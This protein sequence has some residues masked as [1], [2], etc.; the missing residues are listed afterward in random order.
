MGFKKLEI[1]DL[2]G[3]P[4]LLN[5]QEK[6]IANYS[7]TLIQNATGYEADIT[8]LSMI[9]KQVIEQ[10]F[11]KVAPADYMPVKVGEGAWARN[12]VTFRSFVLG[13]DFSTGII[14][15]GS[16]N[17][18]QASADTQVDT[19]NVKQV[20]WAKTIGWS[21]FDLQEASKSGN[22]DLIT[23]MEKAR[24]TNW[25]LGIQKVA[26]LGLGDD[27]N[28]RGLLTQ[29]DVTVNT[30]LLGAKFISDMTDAE[31]TTFCT[32]VYEAYRANSN[33]TAE[34]THF[35]IPEQDYNGLAAPYSA[36]FPL[37]TKLQHLQ[38]MFAMLT[39]NPNFKIM[40]LAYGNRAIHKLAAGGS[41]VHKYC[42][43]NYEEDSMNMNIGVN[44]TATLANTLDGFTF[45][46]TAYGMFT[47]LKAFRPA[48]MLYLT[49]TH[50]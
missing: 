4:I 14:G 32:G 22:W 11:F 10:K 16:N 12:L 39:M 13:D 1:L 20:P 33:R 7:Q 27:L 3:K 31:F 46:N 9:Q 15:A 18:R 42:L 48:E 38:E 5:E 26:F 45:Q 29:S 47:G 8:T 21:I 6:K 37:K 50:A 2:E 30:A 35:V 28:V 24:K 17:A 43:Y 49:S 41:D 25:D 34:P 23:S 44:Y 36:S 19:I 40:K